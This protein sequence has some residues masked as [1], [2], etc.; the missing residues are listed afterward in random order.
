MCV[1]LC[2]CVCV[3]VCL[4]LLILPTRH[5]PTPFGASDVRP[6]V[7]NSRDWPSATTPGWFEFG[8]IGRAACCCCVRSS[9]FRSRYECLKMPTFSPVQYCQGIPYLITFRNDG[10]KYSTTTVMHHQI[11]LH[12]FVALT[13]NLQHTSFILCC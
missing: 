3:C 5:S 12:F 10:I 11:N 13:C 8:I 4:C 6:C 1:C 9:D 2:V 7:L